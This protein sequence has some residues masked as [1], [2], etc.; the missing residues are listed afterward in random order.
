[1]KKIIQVIALHLMIRR[2]HLAF[3]GLF[4]LMQIIS[5]LA[6]AH[7]G[8]GKAVG[9]IHIPWFE[10][11]SKG[12]DAFIQD[13]TKKDSQDIIVTPSQGHKSVQ[14]AIS[15]DFIAEACSSFKYSAFSQ[16]QN[17]TT[18]PPSPIQQDFSSVFA[19][20]PPER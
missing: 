18:H 7:F 11:L 14:L 3:I 17:S 16:A 13:F 19:R 20:A 1:M 4:T 10:V 2:C 6:H 8:E 15:F 5:P 9:F 12:Q